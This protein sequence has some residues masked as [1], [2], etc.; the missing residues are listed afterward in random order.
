MGSRGNLPPWS[1]SPACS[2]SSSGLGGSAD[3]AALG[4]RDRARRRPRE[5]IFTGAIQKLSSLLYVPPR[6]TQLRAP[7]SP[8]PD[9][10]TLGDFA[11]SCDDTLLD[12]A[13]LGGGELSPEGMQRLADHLCRCGPCIQ[14]LVW[15]VA[16]PYDEDEDVEDAA[17]RSQNSDAK[18]IAL[19]Q[20]VRNEL[21]LAFALY[22]SGFMRRDTQRD[23]TTTATSGYWS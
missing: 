1:W 3:S 5:T 7:L 2:W 8:C 14:C 13:C 10:F 20:Q 15:T 12:L 16:V 22:L 21:A 17:D 4:A 18:D 19:A 23:G 9:A 6:F 11:V